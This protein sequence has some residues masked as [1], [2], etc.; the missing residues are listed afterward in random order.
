M[1]NIQN[2]KNKLSNS[3]IKQ[4]KLE[5]MKQERNHIN[6]TSRYNYYFIDLSRSDH[7]YGYFSKW[8]IWKSKR[9]N[10]KI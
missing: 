2:T 5:K 9:R 6:S 1:N 3:L 7:K 10:R 8:I 4:K